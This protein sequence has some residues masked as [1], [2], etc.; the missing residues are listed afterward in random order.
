MTVQHSS[1]DA[2]LERI[3]RMLKAH[4]IAHPNAA[5]TVEGIAS[6]WLADQRGGA[7]RERVE[8]A[9]RQLVD[10]GFV[11]ARRMANGTVIYALN[12]AQ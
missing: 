12:K 6:W 11:T 8:Q 7:S 3:V 10:E 9:L 5:D 4:L 1:V 2:E